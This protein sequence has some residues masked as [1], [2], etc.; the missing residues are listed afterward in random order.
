MKTIRTII[1]LVIAAGIAVACILVY[2]NRG[3]EGDDVKVEKG[4]VTDIRPLI[5]LC[6]MDFYEDVPVRGTVGKKHIFARETLTG[7][8]SFDL[9]SIEQSMRGDTLVVTLAAE[10][11][12]IYESTDPKSYEVIDTWNDSLFGSDNF[13]AAEENKVKQQVKDSFRKTVYKRGYVR[14]ARR[15]A[16]ENL[17]SMLVALRGGK[18]AVVTDP[19]PEG[20]P[21]K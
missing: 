7:S 15:Q 18:P 3:T 19:T 11:V 10:V 1:L 16:V 17:Q 14:E 5:R 6:T 8:I 12:E 4:V 21:G 2:K 13:T 20:N 9:D